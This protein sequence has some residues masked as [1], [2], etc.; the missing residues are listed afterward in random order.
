[1]GAL[2]APQPLRG[3]RCL[4]VSTRTY[5][6]QFFEFRQQQVQSALKMV[7]LNEL[8]RGALLETGTQADIL[9]STTCRVQAGEWLGPWVLCHALQAAVQRARPFGVALHVLAEP[10]GGA[11]TLYLPTLLNKFFP[12]SASGSAGESHKPGTSLNVRYI[13]PHCWA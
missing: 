5:L 3:T 4:R 13:V 6:L 10:G 12:S 2:L 9:T 8:M 1:M 11:P 7:W